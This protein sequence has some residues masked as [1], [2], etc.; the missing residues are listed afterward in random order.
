MYYYVYN[1]N[2]RRRFERAKNYIS[3]RSGS[4]RPR[5]QWLRAEEIYPV[6]TTTTAAAAAA[7]ASVGT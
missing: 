1:I 2:G 5:I 3:T 7:A 4:R 6:K